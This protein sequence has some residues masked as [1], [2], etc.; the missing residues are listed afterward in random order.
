M[1]AEQSAK[2]RQIMIKKRMIVYLLV[3]SGLLITNS[4]CKHEMHDKCYKDGSLSACGEMCQSASKDAKACAE[5]DLLGVNQC[6]K[7]NNTQSCSYMYLFGDSNK[8]LYLN[9][10]KKLCAADKS[11]VGCDSLMTE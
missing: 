6:T 8:E 10:L 9:H 5:R 7:E 1:S 2:W 11:Q 3:A 4:A